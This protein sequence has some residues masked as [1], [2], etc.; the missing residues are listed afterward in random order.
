MNE[1]AEQMYQRY[2]ELGGEDFRAMHNR[3]VLAQVRRLAPADD[4]PD[5]AEQRR[6]WA[7]EQAI[8]GSQLWP[9][10]AV[11]DRSEGEVAGL[12][13]QLTDALA[14]Y[15]EHGLGDGAMALLADA[16][17]IVR[18]LLANAEGLRLPPPGVDALRKWL[19]GYELWRASEWAAAQWAVAP[20]ED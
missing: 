11:V 16:G 19:D 17:Q 1:A 7:A 3:L 15:A 5:G 8:Q 10:S 12:V 13:I 20:T 4:G 18:N 14:T 6:R 9:M 2:L